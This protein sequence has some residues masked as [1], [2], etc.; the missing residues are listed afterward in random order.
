MKRL[1]SK[2]GNV[3]SVIITLVV[4]RNICQIAGDDYVNH[5]NILET[6]TAQG[7]RAWIKR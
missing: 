2:I 1:D 4:L 7:Q 5:G 6:I 3:S